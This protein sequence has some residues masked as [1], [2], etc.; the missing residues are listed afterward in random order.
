MA[1][2]EEPVV[3]VQ[4]DGPIRVVKLNRPDQLNSINEELDNRLATIFSELAEDDS[5]RVIVLTGTGRAFSAGGDFDHLK[6]MYEDPALRRRSVEN[7]HRIVWGMLRCR[8]PIVAAV[9]GPAV[10]LGCSLVA[11]SDTVIMSEKAFLAD[12]HVPVGLVAADGGA[13]L[14]PSHISL[15]LAKEFL[16]TGDRIPA[17]VA[18]LKWDSSIM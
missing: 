14:W 16:F 12:P 7:G 9:N 6:A 8:L 13:L 5:A 18:L 4:A 15:M 2:V 17:R 11:M 1:D 10:G 3:V